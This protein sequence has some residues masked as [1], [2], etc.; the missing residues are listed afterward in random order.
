ML[1]DF[2]VTNH[3]IIE[4]KHLEKGHTQMEVDIVQANIERR[5]KNRMIHCPTDCV[6]VMKECRQ[7]QPFEM[8]EMSHSDILKFNSVSYVQSI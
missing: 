1:L 4:Q 3:V 7:T 8:I 6:N 5:L 2:S